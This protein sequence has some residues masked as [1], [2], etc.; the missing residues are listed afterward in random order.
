MIMLCWLRLFFSTI[1]IVGYASGAVAAD[2]K[3]CIPP[4]SKPLLFIGQDASSIKNYASSFGVPG[5]TMSYVSLANLTTGL[6]TPAEYGSGQ[7]YAQ[8]LVDTYQGTAL[9]LGVWLVGMLEDVVAGNY[10]DKLKDLANW[11]NS[12]KVPVFLRLGYEFDNPDNLYEPTQYEKAYGHIVS[13]L[14]GAKVTNALYVWHSWAQTPWEGIDISNWYPGDNYVDIVGV[15]I[16]EQPLMND[17]DYAGALAA[18]A[19]EHKK[20]LMIAESTPMGGIHEGTWDAWFAPVL[21]WAAKSGVVAWSYINSDWESF[22]MWKGDGFGDTRIQENP[23]V[24]K[25][26]KSLNFTTQA[27]A[28]ISQCLA[29]ADSQSSDTLIYESSKHG[30]GAVSFPGQHHRGGEGPG[31]AAAATGAL[32][33]VGAGAALASARRRRA[34][35]ASRHLLLAAQNPPAAAAAT[36]TA[37]ADVFYKTL[38]VGGEGVDGDQ[39][40]KP[41]YQAVV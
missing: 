22:P 9:N 40:Y 24:M 31:P 14:R 17:W 6:L 20:A 3:L 33:L 16:F 10:D 26:W 13:Y 1:L 27:S 34:L 5:G 15:S 23:S 41:S 21:A 36:S 2:P 7:E 4:A 32:L 29:K 38:P 19:R 28:F 35:L 37:S 18:F 11:L 25:Q 39:L 8:E 30:G 12:I